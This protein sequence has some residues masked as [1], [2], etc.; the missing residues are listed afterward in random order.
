MPAV[1]TLHH[2]SWSDVA[3][4]A[5]APGAVIAAPNSQ[6]V[7]GGCKVKHHIFTNCHTCGK[8]AN[9]SCVKRVLK[10][11]TPRFLA[12]MDGP[13][14]CCPPCLDSPPGA[15]NADVLNNKYD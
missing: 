2:A 10:N 5:A 8:K 1:Y 4:V 14:W 15:Q 13:G 6:C 9:S 3:V 12:G 7:F 11:E